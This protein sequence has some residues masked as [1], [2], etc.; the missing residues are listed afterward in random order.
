MM[1]RAM[2]GPYR[3]YMH[4]CGYSEAFDGAPEHG[5]CDACES[6]SNDPRD[7]QPLFVEVQVKAGPPVRGRRIPGTTASVPARHSLAA[8][9]RRREFVRVPTPAARWSHS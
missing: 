1:K 4:E 5:G 8:P 2:K 9:R 7:W 3:L 6:G